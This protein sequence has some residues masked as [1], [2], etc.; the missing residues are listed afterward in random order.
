VT[1]TATV[2]VTVTV[3]RLGALGPG[4]E[5]CGLLYGCYE[6]RRVEGWLSMLLRRTCASCGL[7]YGFAGFAAIVLSAA[8]NCVHDVIFRSKLMLDVPLLFTSK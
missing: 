3:N 1:V 7:L 2:T 5:S 6:A 4:C 8:V